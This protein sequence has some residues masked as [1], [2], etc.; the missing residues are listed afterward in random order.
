MGKLG[1]IV[2]LAD[3]ASIVHLNDAVGKFI[4]TA[5]VSDNNHAAV[6]PNGAFLE[7]FQRLMAGSG[8]ERCCGLITDDQAGI[9][10]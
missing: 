3:H 9:V 4:N 2:E 6:G 7:E 10:N 8:I 1:W 5:V